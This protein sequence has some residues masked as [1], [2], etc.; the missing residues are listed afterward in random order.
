MTTTVTSQTIWRPSVAMIP[1]PGLTMLDLIGPYEAL[2]GHTDVHLLGSTTQDF[3]S[4][5]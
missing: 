4:H 1:F 2:R 3:F 5:S